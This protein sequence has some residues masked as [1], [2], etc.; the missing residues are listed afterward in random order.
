M[1]SHMLR[2]GPNAHIIHENFRAKTIFD[3]SNC[4]QKLVNMKFVISC[5]PVLNSPK[6]S[7]IDP[8]SIPPCRIWSSARLPVVNLTISARLE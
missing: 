5:K 2:N 8:V 4:L 7:V 3:K 1:N 6:S